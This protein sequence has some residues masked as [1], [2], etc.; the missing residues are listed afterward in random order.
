MS[1][2]IEF[3]LQFFDRLVIRDATDRAEKKVLS[4]FG[5]YVR[6]SAKSSIRQRK[7]ISEPGQPPSSHKGTLKR[8]IF[9]SYDATAQSVVIGP[10]L[11][12]GKDGSVPL[13]LEEGG[14]K[15][16]PV[17]TWIT[18]DH[19]VSRGKGGRFVSGK[20]RVR[21]D[22]RPL[23]Y[24]PRPYM[25]PALQKELPKLPDMWRNSVK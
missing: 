17:G 11:F 16:V 1:A 6:R 25:G 2:P 13:L 20:E 7:N 21:A 24:R 8:L 12:R 9:F 15:H 22:G 5:A 3:K 10:T 23:K 19:G 14:I 18:I 4:K